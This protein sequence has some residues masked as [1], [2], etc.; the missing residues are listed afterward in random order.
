MKINAYKSPLKLSFV[1]V[2]L[3]ANCVTSYKKHAAI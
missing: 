1:V 3:L 2:K